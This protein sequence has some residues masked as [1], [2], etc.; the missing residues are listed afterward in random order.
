MMCNYIHKRV[1]V[2]QISTVITRCE[3]SPRFSASRRFGANAPQKLTGMAAPDADEIVRDYCK[4]IKM[5]V[6]L[7]QRDIVSIKYSSYGRLCQHMKSIE[8]IVNVQP[9]DIVSI[10]TNEIWCQSL[11]YATPIIDTPIINA[12]LLLCNV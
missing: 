8:E 11:R 9:Y 3:T 1:R 7:T 12:Y 10:L 5:Y 4:F 2:L 6:I